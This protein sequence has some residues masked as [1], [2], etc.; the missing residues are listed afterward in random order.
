MKKI[1]IILFLIATTLLV[2]A[3]EK[4]EQS[5]NYKIDEKPSSIAVDSEK[6]S[7]YEAS[8]NIKEKPIKSSK[9]IEIPI[10]TTSNEISTTKYVKV[11]EE[12]SL[13][14][15]MQIIIDT[16]S[17]IGF[18]DLPMNVKVYG[19][20]IARIELIEHN[21]SQ[22][23]RVTWKDDYL[24]EDTKEYTINTIVKNILQ[25]EY[26]GEWIEKIQLYYE[27]ELIEID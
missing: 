1:A 15:K 9:I 11:H 2:T 8:S 23:S 13:Q 21:S 3:C 14:E 5:Y 16:I 6:A 27:G 22:K 12:S 10:T 25:E 7:Q 26:K 19:K 24:N 20:N 17:E 18:N 4:K